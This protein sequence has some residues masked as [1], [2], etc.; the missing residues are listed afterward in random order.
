MFEIFICTCFVH[1]LMNFYMGWLRA[2]V[3]W[4]SPTRL[5]GQP[6]PVFDPFSVQVLIFVGNL[7]KNLIYLKINYKMLFEEKLFT[8]RSIQN[9][10][11]Y[12]KTTTKKYVIKNNDHK[13]HAIVPLI[14]TN[15]LHLIVIS[16]VLCYDYYYVRVH[17]VACIY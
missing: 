14:S 4:Q 10:I 3:G 6:D 8:F 2:R 7:P 11:T 5:Y 17:F 9:Y 13:S 15:L 1:F 16:Q 12:I